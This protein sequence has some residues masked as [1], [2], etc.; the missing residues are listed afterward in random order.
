MC[1]PDGHPSFEIIFFHGLHLDGSKDA[2]L[3]TWLS[4]DGS[5]LWPEWI[6][7]KF[8]EARILLISHDASIKKTNEAGLMDMYVTCEN[9]VHNLM[10]A[11]V[12]EE[13]CPVILVGHS[14]GC[15]VM[16]EICSTLNR[17]LSHDPNKC[18]PNFFINVKGL[19][20]YAC[21]HRGSE[22][23]DSS[24]QF[25]KGS[26]FE[27]LTTLNKVA[28]RRNEDFRKLRQKYKWKTF[29]IGEGL[30]TTFVSTKPFLKVKRRVKHISCNFGE[31]CHKTTKVKS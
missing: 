23:A 9:L 10:E 26:L 27:D 24:T 29:G 30:P 8:P 15:L 1:K 4:A 12:G 2:H 17:N 25:L 3:K 14:I 11:R 19:F 31:R 13:G 7:E 16:K 28:Q 5:Q 6:L 21:P 22:L 20:Y 18:V